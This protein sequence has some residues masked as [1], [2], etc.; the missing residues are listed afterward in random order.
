MQK[1][2]DGDVHKVKA[3]VTREVIGGI[4]VGAGGC[5]DKSISPNSTPDHV[6]VHLGDLPGDLLLLL[7]D[8]VVLHLVHLHVHHHLNNMNHLPNNL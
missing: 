7:E 8:L 6:L 2:K 3:D 5:K 1:V 4:R